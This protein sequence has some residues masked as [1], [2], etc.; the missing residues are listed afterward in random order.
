MPKQKKGFVSG[1]PQR[2]I[3]RHWKK[4][5]GKFKDLFTAQNLC[6]RKRKFTDKD[7]RNELHKKIGG[8][9]VYVG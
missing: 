9:I 1:S 5:C 7:L 6:E 8:L 3:Y 4:T 2:E